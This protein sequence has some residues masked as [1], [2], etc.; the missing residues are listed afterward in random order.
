M[1][2]ELTKSEIQA[3]A[4]EYITLTDKGAGPE[5]NDCIIKDYVF[6]GFD[7]RGMQCNLVRFERCRFVG[8]KLGGSECY[9]TDLIDC[10]FT[11]ADLYKWEIDGDIISGCKFDGARLLRAGIAVA[12]LTNSSFVGAN[13]N[14]TRFFRCE[15]SNVDFTDAIEKREC[16]IT[17]KDGPVDKET[18]RKILGF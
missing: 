13:L 1:Q 5:F 10:D 16:S 17:G 18:R 12:I 15:L 7:F 8:T 14:Q 11:D 2:R 3:I 4:N 9:S 6:S